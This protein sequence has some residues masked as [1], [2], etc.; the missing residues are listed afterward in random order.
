MI[1]IQ[2]LQNLEL[3][4]VIN[5][6]LEEKKQPFKIYVPKETQQFFSEREAIAA[7]YANLAYAGQ[8]LHDVSFEFDYEQ[9]SPD[10]HESVC[11]NL[12]AIDIEIL[13]QVL[14]EISFGYVNGHNEGE[15]YSYVEEAS[16]YLFKANQGEISKIACPYFVNVSNEFENIEEP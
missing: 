7:D 15:E 10:L 8:L 1:E 4:Q 5:L 13:A 2:Q 14:L 11:F 12:K 3:E 6:L 16:D 9:V